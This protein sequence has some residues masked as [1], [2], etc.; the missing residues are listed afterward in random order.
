[1]LI[2]NPQPEDSE[3]EVAAMKGDL[4]KLVVIPSDWGHM[5]MPLMFCRDIFRCP[6]APYSWRGRLRG[7]HE[8]C[9]QSDHEILQ[10][11]LKSLKEAQ[12]VRTL[13]ACQELEEEDGIL[14]HRIQ[15]HC[16][17]ISITI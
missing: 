7:G 9:E 8:V 15:V 14:K 13:K 2:R 4:G 10:G 5:C 11:H 6:D 3:N 12:I 17:L 1:M 16:K